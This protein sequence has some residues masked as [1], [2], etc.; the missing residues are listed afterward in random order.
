MST[1]MQQLPQGLDLIWRM[2]RDGHEAA[3]AL[4]RTPVGLQGVFLM[5]GQMLAGYQFTSY[6][7]LLMWAADKNLDLRGRGWLTCQRALP[8][9][10][11]MESAAQT[12]RDRRK[13]VDRRASHGRAQATFHA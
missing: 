7:Q 9:D 13:S 11:A 2:F 4:E 3:C 8:M 5:D 1:T 6:A 12:F 10:S